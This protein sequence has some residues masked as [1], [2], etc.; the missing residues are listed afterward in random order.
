MSDA[1]NRCLDCRYMVV[2]PSDRFRDGYVGVG[3]LLSKKIMVSKI[4]H[5]QRE[6][7]EIPLWCQLTES[8]KK[9]KKEVKK[10]IDSL[11]N[12]FGKNDKEIIVSAV[13]LMITLHS[14][15]KD[16]LDGKPYIWHTL[17]VANIVLNEFG[18]ADKDIVIAA[19]LHD[20]VEDQATRLAGICIEES[21][22]ENQLSQD[23]LRMY[24]FEALQDMFGKR[25]VRTV[26]GMSNPIISTKN[27]EEKRVLYKNHFAEAVQ[28]TD[29]C[30]VKY[31]DFAGNA[32]QIHKLDQWPRRRLK[33]I[34]KYR[35]V[36]KGVFIPILK[37]MDESHPLYV[38]KKN[39]LNE[40]EEY[41]RGYYYE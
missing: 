21:I 8:E 38:N 41:Y 13:E 14:A 23:D 24:A 30:V 18:V 7:L 34:K 28:D 16:R 5:L 12:R 15:Q 37:N 39:L 33:L 32:L 10:F 4:E 26:K 35:P 6:R 27:P 11:D 36:L 9:I 25:V 1:K 2:F 17:D 29:V 19:L 22:D 3:C 31:A 20:S 40:A